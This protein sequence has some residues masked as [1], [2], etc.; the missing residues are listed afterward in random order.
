VLVQTLVYSLRQGDQLSRLMQKQ[1]SSSQ[2]AN[3]SN[4]TATPTSRRFTGPGLRTGRYMLT[5]PPDQSNLAGFLIASL[6][7]SQSMATVMDLWSV[8][9]PASI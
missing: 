3:L 6:I 7:G 1:V 5:A 4:R 2:P 8:C 9:S